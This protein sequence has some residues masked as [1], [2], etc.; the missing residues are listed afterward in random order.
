MP[1]FDSSLT[2]IQD[3]V[4][5]VGV[6]PYSSLG[7]QLWP[8]ATQTTHGR[9]E[10]PQEATWVFSAVRFDSLPPLPGILVVGKDLGLRCLC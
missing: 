7:A 8:K 9:R 1:S 4:L 5:L 2:P 10:V 6:T 3:L